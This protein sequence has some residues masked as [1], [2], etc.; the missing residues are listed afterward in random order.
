MTR[1]ESNV[2]DNST[3]RVLSLCR[4][5][6]PPVPTAISEAILKGAVHNKGL[7]V[8]GISVPNT[9]ELHKLVDE[10]EQVNSKLILDVEYYEV[11]V[12]LYCLYVF[13]CQQISLDFIY[14]DSS[15]TVVVQ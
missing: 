14:I 8:I 6:H 9:V 10:V 12:C 5:D 1:L 13:V 2:R 15:L 3:M 4:V 7:R 11:G